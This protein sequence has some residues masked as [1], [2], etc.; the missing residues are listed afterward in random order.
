MTT[1]KKGSI[2][3]SDLII[4]YLACTILKVILY[5][6]DFC[7]ATVLE[8]FDNLKFNARVGTTNGFLSS[9]ST[10][11]VSFYEIQVIFDGSVSYIAQKT[12]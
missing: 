1:A 10:N 4:C 12:E 8:V 11:K 9:D 6:S 7:M 3:G 2:S 5:Q